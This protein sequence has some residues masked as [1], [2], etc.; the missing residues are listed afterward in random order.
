MAKTRGCTSKLTHAAHDWEAPVRGKGTEPCRCPGK[1][2]CVICKKA[3]Y[4]TTVEPLGSVAGGGK[5]SG[6]WRCSP[7]CR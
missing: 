4:R 6:G 3:V 5:A 7:G 1:V 2:R